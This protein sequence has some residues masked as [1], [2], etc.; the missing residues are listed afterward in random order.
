MVES[1]LNWMDSAVVVKENHYCQFTL[2]I[3][4]AC[5]PP[6]IGKDL[7]DMEDLAMLK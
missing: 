6:N 4:S 5:P 7:G 3:Q 2:L 1:R